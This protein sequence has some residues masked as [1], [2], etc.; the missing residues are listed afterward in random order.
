[1]ELSIGVVEHSSVKA[2]EPMGSIAW[3]SEN[4]RE[5][6]KQFASE[7]GYDI[8]EDRAKRKGWDDTRRKESALGF[9]NFQRVLVFPYNVPKTTLTL[10]WETGRDSRRWQPLFPGFD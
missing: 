4:E 1:V 5:A 9:S 2:F 6:L 10:L 7:V 8:L 3:A